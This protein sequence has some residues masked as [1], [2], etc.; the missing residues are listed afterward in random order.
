MNDSVQKALLG[1]GIGVAAG[2]AVL[3][4]LGDRDDGDDSTGGTADQAK[5]AGRDAAGEP[6]GDDDGDE[7]LECPDCGANSNRKGEPFTTER[8]VKLHR[9]AAHD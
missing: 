7:A 6:E 2:L 4:F 3:S 5:A 9:L 1:A 8:Q